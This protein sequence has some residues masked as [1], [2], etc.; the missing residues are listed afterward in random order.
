MKA[1]EGVTSPAK[2]V[3]LFT[4]SCEQNMQKPAILFTSYSR[5]FPRSIPD[6]ITAPRDA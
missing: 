3:F 1:S 4:K 6:V 2:S 5:D